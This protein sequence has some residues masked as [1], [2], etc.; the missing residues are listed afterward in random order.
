MK[1]CGSSARRVLSFVLIA[2]SLAA[3]QQDENAVRGDLGKNGNR[4]LRR[5][6]NV[7]TR[8]ANGRV[9]RTVKA[10]SGPRGLIAPTETETE[11]ANRLVGTWSMGNWRMRDGV[12][13]R[14]S[15]VFNSKHEFEI[16]TQRSSNRST[17]APEIEVRTK[18]KY[19]IGSYDYYHHS[20]GIDLEF[21]D[22]DSSRIVIPA[23]PGKTITAADREMIPAAGSANEAL[24]EKYLVDYAGE[25]SGKTMPVRGNH[26]SLY[27]LAPPEGRGAGP[28][29]QNVHKMSGF[30]DLI[31][32]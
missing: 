10:P 4:G 20:Y 30:L 23:P 8:H 25:L 15:I 18:G 19:A 2:F 17:P 14:L 24:A 1:L 5:R 7:G 27:D 12:N 16:Q 32:K 28:A 29:V 11:F 13:E 3:C 9:D 22:L 21:G 31:K 6:P 26:L